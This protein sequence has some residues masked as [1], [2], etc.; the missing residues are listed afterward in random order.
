MSTTYTQPAASPP[1]DRLDPEL[2]ELLADTDTTLDLEDHARARDLSAERAAQRN[3]NRP[4]RA[5]VEVTELVVARATAPDVRVRSYRPTGRRQA[6]PGVIHF[7]GGAFIVGN[8]ETEDRD[9]RETSFQT[10]CAV[11][12]VD[13]RLAPEDPFPAAV[14]DGF[15]VL[16]WAVSNADLLGIDP[17][18]LAVSGASAGGCIAAV[19][20]MMARDQDGPPLRLQQLIYPVLDDRMRTTSARWDGTPM[21]THSQLEVMWRRYLGE[22]AGAEDVS[23]YAAPGRQIDLAGLPATYMV[24]AGLDPLRDEAL[25]FATRLI[26]A[27]VPVELHHYSDVVHGFDKVGDSAIGGRSIRDRNAAL[28]AALTRPSS[29]L[30]GV[31]FVDE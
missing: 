10:G 21:L 7:H 8:L 22:R 5:E 4:H 18:R 25:D 2:A 20:A 1:L 14:Q 28:A 16:R 19:V 26:D 31:G 13:Y 27:G 12:S 6:L 29:R 15:D 24:V 11:L 30:T 17:S 3:A 9:C 23:P